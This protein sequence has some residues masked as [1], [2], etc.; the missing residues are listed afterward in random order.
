MIFFVKLTEHPRFPGYFLTENGRVFREMPC[1][2]STDGYALVKIDGSKAG[3]RTMRRHTLLAETFIGPRQEGDVVR[4][5]DGDRGNDDL[6]NLEW[7]TPK[8]N[9]ADTVRH[10]RTLRGE[11]QRNSKLTES[12]VLEIRSRVADGES[13]TEIA[14]DFGVSLPTIN[15]IMRGRTWGWLK[16]EDAPS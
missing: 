16:T 4:H 5:L 8:E 6:S 10:G 13:Q 11:R 14:A 12:G 7:G 1:T 15:D 2:T 9:A 3:T